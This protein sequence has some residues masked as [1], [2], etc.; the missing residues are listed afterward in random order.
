[1]LDRICIQYQLSSVLKVAPASCRLSQSLAL[2]YHALRRTLS[3]SRRTRS[4]STLSSSLQTGKYKALSK[5]TTQH[6][7]LHLTP[8]H[9]LGFLTPFFLTSSK[10]FFFAVGFDFQYMILRSDTRNNPV[11]ASTDM[12]TLN[13]YTSVLPTPQ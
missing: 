10:L 6:V 8:V 4:G 1:M 2:F 13:L 7:D 11:R 3:L 9:G 5:P 12:T